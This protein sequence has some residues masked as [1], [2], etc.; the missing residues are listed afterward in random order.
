MHVVVETPKGSL[1]KVRY[2][3]DLDAFAFGR[4]LALGSAYPDD[5][6]FVPSTCA[7]DS[8]PI[9]AMLLFDSPTWPGIVIGSRI[10]GIGRLTQRDEKGKRIANDRVIGVPAEDH[11]HDDVRQLTKR[12][13]HELEHFFVD[14]AAMTH[15]QVIVEGWDGP[16]KASRA[17]EAAARAYMRGRAPG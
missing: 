9:D 4:V 5:W 13:R 12:T 15:K 10:I 16:K 2:D 11:R 14:V 3:G 1:V 17:V 7:Q 6:G 8:D